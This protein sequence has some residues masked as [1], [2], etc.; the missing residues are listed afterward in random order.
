LTDTAYGRMIDTRDC[1]VAHGFEVPEPPSAETWKDSDWQ[2]A[3]N[4]YDDLVVGQNALAQDKLFA[5]AQ[6]CPQ[7]GPNFQILAPTS[8]Y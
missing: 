4:P 5:L 7:P 6:A 1:I 3:W 8:D 2:S